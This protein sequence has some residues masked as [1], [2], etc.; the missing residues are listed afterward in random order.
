MK[1]VNYSETL[2]KHFGLD[3][4]IGEY[5]HL[6]LLYMCQFRGVYLSFFPIMFFSLEFCPTTNDIIEY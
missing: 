1:D 6:F 2:T 4:I 3:S 5:K